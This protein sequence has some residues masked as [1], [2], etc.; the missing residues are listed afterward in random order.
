MKRFLSI[1]IT[2]S[3]LIT[4]S[5]VAIHA[6]TS[7]G[8]EKSDT[9]SETKTAVSGEKEVSRPEESNEYVNFAS[10]V[11]KETKF[12]DDSIIVTMKRGVKEANHVYTAEDFPELDVDY[13]EDLTYLTNKELLNDPEFMANYTQILQIHLKNPSEENVL[14]SVSSLSK[15]SVTDVASVSPNYY[16]DTKECLLP[17]SEVFIENQKYFANRIN[18]PAAWE[19]TTGSSKVKVAVIDGG[20]TEHPGLINNIS[21]CAYDAYH[22]VD[23]DFGQD[24]EDLITTDVPDDHGTTVAGIIGAS[25]SDTD[26]VYGVAWNV[27]LVPIQHTAHGSEGGGHTSTFIRIFTYLN[28]NNI[29]IANYSHSF[30]WNEEP[31]EYTLYPYRTAINN[32]FGLLITS[33]GN[34]NV[35]ISNSHQCYPTRLNCN[36]IITVMATDLSNGNEVKADSSNYSETYVDIAAPW[37]GYT[38]LFF[39]SFTSIEISVSML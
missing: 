4:S 18:L 31:T 23:S 11:S 20:I 15:R 39:I 28:N 21:E 35:N 29:P 27:D 16:I 26:G 30:G 3:I 7:N 25:G 12:A 36:N 19:Y 32:Y 13:V 34:D 2:L 38:T 37:S 24:P 5:L 1:I 33:A 22:D 6:D 14:S 17:Q 8:S 10:A 9:Q